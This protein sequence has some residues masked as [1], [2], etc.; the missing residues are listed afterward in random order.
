MKLSQEAASPASLH[1]MD[2]DADSAASSGAVSPST[3]ECFS[4]P[5]LHSRRRSMRRATL[6]GTCLSSWEAYLAL[7]LQ[8]LCVLLSTLYFR[9]SLAWRGEGLLK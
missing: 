6:S 5:G 3:S 4:T 7:S 9:Q 8:T 2:T 1:G